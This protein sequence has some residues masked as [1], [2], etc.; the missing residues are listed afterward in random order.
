MEPME[1]KFV[2]LHTPIFLAGTN[3][4]LKLDP[5]KRQGLKLEYYRDMQELHVFYKDEMAIVPLP[6]VASLVPGK[7]KMPLAQVSH[8]MLASIGSAQ[9]ETPSSHVHAGMGKGRK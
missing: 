6:N 1:L 5:G 2:E 8:P 3:M 7:P 4:G 9:V